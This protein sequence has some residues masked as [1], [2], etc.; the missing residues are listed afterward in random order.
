MPNFVCHLIAYSNPS[1]MGL[2]QDTPDCTGHNPATEHLGRADH[3]D[4]GLLAYQ[5]VPEFKVPLTRS[6]KLL[7]FHVSRHPGYAQNLCIKDA[8]PVAYWWKCLP[9]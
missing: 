8:L 9:I 6:E 4:R 5:L 2:H 1:L 7:G 3:Q